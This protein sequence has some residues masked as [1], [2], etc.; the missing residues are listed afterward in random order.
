MRNRLYGLA[1]A[2][3]LAC[4]A[5]WATRVDA[6]PSGA[7]YVINVI[8]P[9]TGSGAFL[10]KDYKEAFDALEIAI[11]RSGGIA[12]RPVKFQLA[13]S[14]T[15]G[16][17]GLQLANAFIAKHAQVFIDGGPSTVCNATVPVVQDTGPVDYCL[18][19]VIRP[20]SGSY[21]FSAGMPSADQA[22]ITLRFLKA[23][24]LTKIGELSSTDSTGADL[25]KQVDTALSSSEFKGIDVVVRDHF[26]PTD[27]GVS[28]QIAHI[29]SASPQVVLI[30]GTGTP[31]GT[32][33]RGASDGGIEVPIVST[34]SNMTYSQMDTFKAYL[35]RDLW[36]PALLAM[37]PEA[38]DKG[39]LH[40]A[41]AA[42][43]RSFKAV[44]VTPD[45]GH[46]LAWDPAMIIVSALRK[47]GPDANAQQIR[48]DI[49][50]LHGYIGVD[51]VYD[52]SNS[53]QRG[54]T[55]KSGAMARWDALK[56]RWVRIS[57]PGGYL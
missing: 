52:F 33:L 57:R 35:P 23:K 20:K 42:Y 36:F 37:T 4:V 43:Y 11:N 3:L 31:F 7:P 16:Q 38:T 28:A 9:M 32:A 10:G 51:G 13:D 41:Q 19:P 8:A 54:I 5:S 24:G 46:I 15:S 18:S 2:A 48:D 17:V 12:G 29:K 47:L 22:K 1:V 21:I 49:L 40:D 25:E 30:W 45:E 53:D 6:A 50:H 26:N 44:G 56:R 27:I 39:P 34:N 14:Q 55:D